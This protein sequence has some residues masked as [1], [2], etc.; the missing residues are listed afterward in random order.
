VHAPNN[1]PPPVLC[2]LPAGCCLPLREIAPGLARYRISGKVIKGQPPGGA[3]DEWVVTKE[4]YD[5]IAVAG[6]LPGSPVGESSLFGRFT[7]S[8]LYQTFRGWVNGPAGQRLGLTPIP[9]GQVNLRTLRR[10]LAI[11][12]AYRPG[13]LLAAKIHLEHVSMVISSLN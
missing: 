10:T 13:G 11:E 8:V 1:T 5:A 6:K 12:L 2:E 9:P 4:V 7:F 3:A